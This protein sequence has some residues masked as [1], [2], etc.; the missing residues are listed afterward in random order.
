MNRS[1][2]LSIS[3][4]ILGDG[5]NLP[6]LGLFGFRSALLVSDSCTIDAELRLPRSKCP[7]I[8]LNFRFACNDMD[9]RLSE[10]SLIRK[11]MGGGAMAADF[12]IPLS[13]GGT[14]CIDLMPKVKRN[15]EQRGKIPGGLS[16]GVR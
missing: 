11:G 6:P 16:S 4:M 8:R 5:S 2:A 7:K 10:F 12:V 14:F 3:Q 9:D 13:G 1:S 15:D